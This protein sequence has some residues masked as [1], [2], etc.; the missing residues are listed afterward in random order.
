[1]LG[2]KTSDSAPAS[3][4]KE[5][6]VALIGT[7]F[8]GK[9]HSHSYRTVSAIFPDAPRPRMKVIVGRDRARAEAMAQRFGWEEVSTDW[10]EVI[11]RPDIDAVDV[12]VHGAMHAPISIAAARAGKH[13]LCEKPLANTLTEAREM[14]AAVRDAGVVNAVQFN[15]R[16][17]PAVI[18]S[19]QLVEE[20]RLG[21]IHH[22]RGKY[23]QDWPM[24]PE[25]PA[26]WRFDKKQAGSGTLG[27]L[28]AHIVDLCHYL[29]GDVVEVSG[30]LETFVKQRPTPDGR[31]QA[32][33]TVDDAA[34]FVAR[35]SNGAVASFE[36]TRFAPGRKNYN[37]FEINGSRGSLYFNLEQLNEVHYYSSDD[38][39][40]TRGFRTVIVTSGSEH[41]YVGNWWPEGHIIGWEHSH[42]HMIHDFLVGI[43][44]GESPRPNFE[45]GVKCQA[46]LDAV[47]R[48][49]QSRRW[50]T[51]TP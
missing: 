41:P 35:L 44:K 29:V 46:V 34:L 47:E 42:T 27:D 23:L 39:A 19:R 14:L 13:V 22:F 25:F 11:R 17:V 9:A 18:L 10:E 37:F 31:G 48:S 16:R 28:G 36:A 6:S 12:S 24:S 38:P 4:K 5:I 21:Q 43:A 33:V 2:Q 15:Y 45:D 49:A 26:V 51:V 30:L 8:M 40:D 32:P 20:G 50:E 7:R 1:M 3:P